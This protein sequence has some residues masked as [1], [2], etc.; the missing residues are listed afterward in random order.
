[1]RREKTSIYCTIHKLFGYAAIHEAGRGARGRRAVRKEAGDAVA[2]RWSE[3]DQEPTHLNQRP[4]LRPEGLLARSLACSP[5][6]HGDRERPMA[7]SLARLGA[8]LPRARPRSAAR[9]LPP[10]RW[11]AAALGASRRAAPNGKSMLP[12]HQFRC[13]C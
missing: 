11:D 6:A 12:T 9:A 10:G 8:A 13:Y 7:S 5:P 4:P 3:V 1:M 2:S